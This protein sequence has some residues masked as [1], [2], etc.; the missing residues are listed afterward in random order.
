MNS[1]RIG[2]VLITFY[3]IFNFM[4]IT[5]NIFVFNYIS[6]TATPK[7]IYIIVA[8]G[9]VLS[10]LHCTPYFYNPSKSL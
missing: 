10:H 2:D 8:Q 9:A 4:H 7:I 3:H 5:G 1:L 6:S